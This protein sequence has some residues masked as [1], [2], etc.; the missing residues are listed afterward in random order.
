VVVL[1]VLVVL[2]VVEEWVFKG[3]LQLFQRYHLLA[4][5]EDQQVMDLLLKETQVDLVV[6]VAVVVIM[7]L[8]V[9]L[10]TLLL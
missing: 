6:Q 9:A 4:A 10:E 3:V 7:L 1:L 2:M 5:E 8:L